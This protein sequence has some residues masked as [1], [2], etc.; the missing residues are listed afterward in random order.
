MAADVQL[1]ERLEIR[2]R[3]LLETISLHFRAYGRAAH[4]RHLLQPRQGFLKRRIA[5]GGRLLVGGPQDLDLGDVRS[6]V[7]VRYLPGEADAAA[8]RNGV[9]LFIEGRPVAETPVTA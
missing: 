6:F 1:L 2:H 7:G 4:G 5:P 8:D 9:D 3:E